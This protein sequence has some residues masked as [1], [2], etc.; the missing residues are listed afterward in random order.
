MKIQPSPSNSNPTKA[1]SHL[2]HNIISSTPYFI[3]FTPHFF[4]KFLVKLILP[5]LLKY[6]IPMYSME[7]NKLRRNLSRHFTVP[8]LLFSSLEG[9]GAFLSVFPA[10]SQEFHQPHEHNATMVKPSRLLIL[11]FCI[12]T[13]FFIDGS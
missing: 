7:T 9:P 10:F 4:N 3:S 1:R 8:F 5:R 13:D 2:Y 11:S 6:S 12:K